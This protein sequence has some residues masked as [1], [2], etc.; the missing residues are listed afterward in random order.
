MKTQTVSRVNG[1][2]LESLGQLVEEIKN[3]P[4][5]G[6]ARFKVASSWKG[7]TRSEARVESYYIN[8][9]EIPRRFSIMADEPPELLGEN[10]AP[11]PQELLMAAFNACIMVGYV[12]TASVL[13]VHLDSVEIETE[14]ELNLRG[15]LGIDDD[16]KP[17]YDSIQYTVRLKGT[18]SRDQFQAIHDNVLR[19][20]PN[21]FNISRPVRVDSKLVI[22]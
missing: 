2:D 19:T 16:V 14:G 9:Q 8:G 5:K 4:A 11:N 21:Y 12:A 3:D 10:S 17:G 18:G 6:Y 15:F 1:L 13:G 7:Q 20:S 22:G